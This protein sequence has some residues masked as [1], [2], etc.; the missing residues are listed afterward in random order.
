MKCPYQISLNFRIPFD[1][2]RRLGMDRRIDVVERAIVDTLAILENQR[3]GLLAVP[4]GSIP[5]FI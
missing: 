1:N 5:L 4:N 3:C 2:V